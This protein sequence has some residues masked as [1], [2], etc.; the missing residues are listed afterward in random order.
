MLNARRIA[1]SRSLAISPSLKFSNSFRSAMTPDPFENLRLLLARAREHIDDLNAK[2]SAFAETKP[3]AIVTELESETGEYV[4]KVR[5]T[6]AAPPSFVMVAADALNNLKSTLDQTVCASALMLRPGGSLGGICFP[7]GDTEDHFHAA[8]RIGCKKIAPEIKSIIRG[9]KPYKGGNDPLWV[10]NSLSKANRHRMLQLV[11]LA[12]ANAIGVNY[13][14]LKGPAKI[15]SP[16]W[17]TSK[18]EM[19]FA[20]TSEPN[21]QYDLQ[22]VFHI[23][24][25]DVDVVRNQPAVPILRDFAQIVEG[26]L[27]AIEAETRRILAF[28]S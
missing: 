19:I 10:M 14:V 13:M 27:V 21:L 17:D 12:A 25:G 9:F 24:F 23:V 26:V 1:S 8:E 28:G 15:M 7:F 4:Y 18:H 11:V 22:F 5:C 3:Y 16:I 20:R 6:A 2:G